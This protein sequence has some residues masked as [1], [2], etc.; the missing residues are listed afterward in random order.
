M[1]VDTTSR[2]P[3]ARD[4]VDRREALDSTRHRLARKAL[5]ARIDR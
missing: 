3:W 1:I 2:V 5:Q 4:E